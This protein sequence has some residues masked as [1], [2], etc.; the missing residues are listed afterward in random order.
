VN[1]IKTTAPISIENLKIYFQDKDNTRFM[2]TG[3]TMD[4]E[5]FIN[6]LS[7]INLPIDIKMSDGI[8]KAYFESKYMIKCDALSKAAVDVLLEYKNISDTDTYIEFIKDN[9]T[10]VSKWANILDSLTLYNM[11]II[12][13]KSM[14]EYATS[15]PN[16]ES[17][18]CINFVNILDENFYNSYFIDEYFATDKS[19]LKFYSTFFKGPISAKIELYTKWAIETNPLFLIT[20]AIASGHFTGNNND[21]LN[22]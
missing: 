17:N 1:I 5:K 10:I 6:Y 9:H 12:Q 3:Y 15:Y 11:Y 13:D 18:D 14:Q 16:D 8:L 2:V 22:R 19:E 21:T 7:N 20:W 4:D